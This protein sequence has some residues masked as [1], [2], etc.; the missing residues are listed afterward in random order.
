MITRKFLYDLHRKRDALWRS[1]KL[2][3]NVLSQLSYHLDKYPLLYRI[4]YDNLFNLII[5]CNGKISA[6]CLGFDK[7]ITINRLTQAGN[8]NHHYKSQSFMT[9]Q[10]AVNYILKQWR[11]KWHGNYKTISSMGKKT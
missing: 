2:S 11:I 5:H 7:Q 4:D 8:I 9:P 6:I 3:A 10:G 1:N